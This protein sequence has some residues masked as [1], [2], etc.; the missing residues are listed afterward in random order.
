MLLLLTPF[1]LGTVFVMYDVRT[2]LIKYTFINFYF[3]R[4]SVLAQKMSD[5]YRRPE[6]TLH[7]QIHEP[8]TSSGP[9]RGAIHAD[10]KHAEHGA[11]STFTSAMHY[12]D[13]ATKRRDELM[14][15]LEAERKEQEATAAAEE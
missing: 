7:F 9:M 14:A 3:Y 12:A 13:V 11:L 1:L 5:E 2:I 10:L 4:G 8:R 6:R 15:K